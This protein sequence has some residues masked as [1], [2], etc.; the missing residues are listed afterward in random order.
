MGNGLATYSE[1]PTEP[2]LTGALSGKTING[3]IAGW[4]NSCAMT[5]ENKFYC[6][7]WNNSAHFGISGDYNQYNTPVLAVPGFV[8]Q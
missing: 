3:I 1:Y 2:T 6:W 5:T 7:G 8:F 4:Y